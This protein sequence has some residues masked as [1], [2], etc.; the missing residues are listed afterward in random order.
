MKLQEWLDEIKSGFERNAPAEVLKIMHDATTAILD[1]GAI[2][3][4]IK[5]GKQLPEFELENLKGEIVSS[6]QLIGQ[7]KLVI[8]FYRGVW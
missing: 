3:N 1:S 6:S 4:V 5:P 7:G 2:D 8:S